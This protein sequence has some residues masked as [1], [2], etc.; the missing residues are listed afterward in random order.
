MNEALVTFSIVLTCELPLG[1][2]ET[3]VKLSLDLPEAT[4]VSQERRSC[5]T[6]QIWPT[7]E[8][9]SELYP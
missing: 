7:G 3:Q 8:V 6:Q 5:Q 2:Q 1:G 9:P 4:K